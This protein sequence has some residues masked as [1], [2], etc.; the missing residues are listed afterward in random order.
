M[1]PLV[2]H[3]WDL[4]PSDAMALQRELS[5][6]VVPFGE[7]AVRLVAGIDVSVSKGSDVG[8][9]AVVVMDYPAL[10]V[11]EV[12]TASFRISMPYIPGLLSFRETPVIMKALEGL[13]R[14]PDLLMV[15]GQGIAH[16]RG[17]GIA[18]H[19]GVIYDKPA[20]GVAK[21]ILVGEYREPPED[22]GS[23][24]P[25]IYKGETVGAILRTKRKVKPV[26]VSVGHRVSLEFAVRFVT[27]CCRGYRLPEPTRRAHI[28]VNRF[29]KASQPKA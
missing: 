9:A 19:I 4:A 11:V 2:Q 12:S 29:R 23:W 17:F 8:F 13:K 1:R 3:P 15:D 10:R 14:E 16:P 27:N 18:S 5:S 28:E 21:S 7:P 25:L 6:R 22:P 20:I 26:F 24:E